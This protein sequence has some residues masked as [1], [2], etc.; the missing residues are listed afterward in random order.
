MRG[1]VALLSGSTLA[2]AMLVGSAPAQA[3]VRGY[4][5]SF[6]G[7]SA[8]LNLAF[9]QSGQFAA[10][11]TNTGT[12]AWQRNTVSQVNLGICLADKVT[13]N[14]TSP[15]ASWNDGTW[16]SNI[17]YATSST[18]LVAP[19]QN[20]FFTYN[21]RAPSTGGTGTYRFNGELVHASTL[22][23]L[24]A[25]GYYQ[26][27]TLNVTSDTIPPNAVVFSGGY[28][29][30]SGM[31]VVTKGTA[32][33]VGGAV[34]TVSVKV[35][36]QDAGVW[37]DATSYATATADDGIFNSPLELF[38]QTTGTLTIPA[39]VPVQVLVR[40]TDF[41]GNANVFTSPLAFNGG[42][43]SSA[44]QGIGNDST[45]P[46]LTATS[47]IDPFTGAVAGSCGVFT[48]A[49]TPSG[50]QTVIFSAF[51][52]DNVGVAGAEFAVTR[53][54]SGDTVI[55]WTACAAADGAF[56]SLQ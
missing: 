41:G 38:T 27:A 2:V 47:C 56:G 49:T 44:P 31:T 40:V 9:G 42:L 32:Y 26:D 23:V 6:F 48:N 34:A 21:V 51:A 37:G 8:F 1:F 16:L 36:R 52:S 45:A 13:C 28:P 55:G 17:A 35:Q 43:W 11:F 24:R 7:E 3:A 50:Q 39:G 22:Q 33:D 30:Q 46:T 14:V 18:D 19:G 54:G 5:S 29:A 15:N 53:L 25:Q 4:D 12:T 10:I 20:A